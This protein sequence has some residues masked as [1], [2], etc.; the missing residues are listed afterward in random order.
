MSLNSLTRWGHQIQV[1]LSQNPFPCC[2]FVSV[3]VR[4]CWNTDSPLWIKTSLVHVTSRRKDFPQKNLFCAFSS[5]AIV[6]PLA[7]LPPNLQ[8]SSYLMLFSLPAILF[9][10][11]IK[12]FLF[13]EVLPRLGGWV[14]RR[15]GTNW[16]EGAVKKAM[17]IHNLGRSKTFLNL[18]LGSGKG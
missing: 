14:H 10:L 2:F 15:M 11:V 3:V 12:C 5:R 18:R 17:M 7:L 1:S 4:I 9:L 16:R 6:L 13:F 8:I